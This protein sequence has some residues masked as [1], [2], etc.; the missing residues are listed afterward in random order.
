MQKIAL[1]KSQYLKEL[2][3]INWIVKNFSRRFLKCNFP[4]I[5]L[6][7]SQRKIICI[8]FSLSYYPFFLT[9]EAL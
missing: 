1:P 7:R 8:N 3:I 2:K 4:R 5:L 6:F 9:S